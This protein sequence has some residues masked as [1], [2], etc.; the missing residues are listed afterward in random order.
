MERG[1]SA[2]RITSGS[3][4]LRSTSERVT[5]VSPWL[6]VTVL[7]AT[8]RPLCMRSTAISRGASGLAPRAKTVWIV[9]T[10]FPSWPASPAITDCARSCPPKTTPWVELRLSAR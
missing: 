8:E 1:V 6:I 4:A 2:W 10:D 5:N 9:L 3:S 7:L